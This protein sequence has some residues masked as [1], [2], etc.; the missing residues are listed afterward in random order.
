MITT[1]YI[2]DGNYLTYADL[3]TLISTSGL[4]LGMRYILTDYQ[5][6]HY[7]LDFHG[8][9]L[10]GN[11]VN[12]GALEHIILTASS[13]NT[14]EP[15]VFSLEFPQDILFYD[16]NPQNW[17]SDAAFTLDSINIIPD[18]KGVIFTREDTN[19]HNIMSE[20]FR[21]TKNRRWKRNDQ[22]WVSGNTYN[23]GDKV[24]ASGNTGGVYFSKITG[25]IGNE[26]IETSSWQK[27]VSYDISEYWC[28]DSTKTNDIND[29]IDV[30]T[31]VENGLGIYDTC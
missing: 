6:T 3:V 20:D 24:Q 15:E 10:V 7:I 19:N 17:L 16:W 12:T 4:T 9:Q 18:F 22:I 29:F 2:T 5:T 27:I 26:L 14:F 13:V 28:C 21:N 30:S 31:F 23:I 25:N 11:P 8:N 1:K